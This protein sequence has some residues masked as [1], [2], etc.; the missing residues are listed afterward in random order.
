MNETPKTQKDV[1]PEKSQVSKLDQLLHYFSLPEKEQETFLA[2]QPAGI[3]NAI[4][5]KDVAF[6]PLS[7]WR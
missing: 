5:L 2:L 6:I 4:E 7:F 3:R 1:L